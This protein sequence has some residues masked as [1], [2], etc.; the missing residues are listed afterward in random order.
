MIFEI[1]NNHNEK[2][3]KFFDDQRASTYI[4]GIS[5][6]CSS[7]PGVDIEE[8]IALAS[9][10]GSKFIPKVS[11]TKSIFVSKSAEQ[12]RYSFKV[13]GTKS[14]LVQSQR[15]KIDI[16]SKSAQWGPCVCFQYGRA[17]RNRTGVLKVQRVDMVWCSVDISRISGGILRVWWVLEVLFMTI[18]SVIFLPSRSYADFD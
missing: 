18:S 17:F 11:G 14:I 7:R 5:L 3:K 16:R 13:S 4:Y 10:F 1:S 12:S 2:R 15:N 9:T 6:I 8:I